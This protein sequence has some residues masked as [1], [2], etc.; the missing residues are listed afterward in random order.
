VRVLVGAWIGST[1]LGDELLLAALRRKLAARGAA[2]AAISLNPAA[3]R[4]AQ[5]VGAVPHRRPARIWSALGSA[6]AFLFGGGGLLQDETSRFNLPFHL[7]RVWAAHAR[8]LPVAGVGLGAGPLTTPSGCA[9]VGRSFSGCPLSVRDA[10]SAAL[11]RG[12]G[13]D[14]VRLAADLALSLPLPDVQPADELVVALRPWQGRGIPPV[15]HRWAEGLGHEWF[16]RG[17][18]EALDRTAASTGLGV[19]FVAFQ[20]DRDDV[21][22]RLVAARMR[23][24]AVVSRPTL[25]TILPEIARARVVVAM[26]YHG[27]I[28]ALLG[29]RPAVLLSYS[30]KVASLAAEVG[31][32]FAGLAWDEEAVRGLTEHVRK[33][34]DRSDEVTAARERLRAREAVNDEVVDDLLERAARATRAG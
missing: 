34:G 7:S 21:L 30:D 14:G 6:D 3:T 32:G 19:R 22:H 5:A 10:D 28:A 9:M 26:R 25:D 1:N 33:V 16:V 18:A 11:L 13:L 12:L 15:E 27:G 29:G 31:P 2:V 4:S 8:G 17:M 23:T 24:P 20:Q